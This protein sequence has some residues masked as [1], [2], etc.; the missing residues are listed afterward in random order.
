MAALMG[1]LRGYRK[2]GVP[3]QVNPVTALGDGSLTAKAATWRT[4]VE[5][6]LHADGSGVIE[7]RQNG[8]V[9]H[10]F[11]FGS[12]NV[13]GD[14]TKRD[15]V[16][17]CPDCGN[18]IAETNIVGFGECDGACRNDPR[19]RV[20]CAECGVV[21]ANLAELDEHVHRAKQRGATA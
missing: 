9:I 7:V 17:R 4:F 1:T 11:G 20:K 8:N 16:K 3:R 13:N 14:P 15:P 19:D 21:F 10:R 2:S 12:E 18:P 6:T 5:T